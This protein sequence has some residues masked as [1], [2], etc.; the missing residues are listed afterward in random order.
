[1]NSDRVKTLEPAKVSLTPQDAQELQQFMERVRRDLPDVEVAPE[2]WV[3]YAA[4]RVEPGERLASVLNGPH[5]QEMYLCA[6]C[7][8]NRPG[9]LAFLE[10]RY[11]SGWSSLLGRMGLDGDTIADVVQRVRVKLVMNQPDKPGALSQYSGRGSLEAF[12][13][14]V[15]TRGGLDEL[16]QQ[17]RELRKEPLE[18]VDDCDVGHEPHLQLLKQRYRDEFTLAVKEGLDAL[19]EKERGL[20]RY[21]YLDG[22][23]LDD[24]ALVYAVHRATVARWLAKAR[25]NLLEATRRTLTTKLSMTE[26]DFNSI[27]RLI[28]SELHVSIRQHLQS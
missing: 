26:D 23:S 2:A 15:V 5:A 14:V 24:M 12:L 18:A 1:M 8:E 17:G 20:L 10:R 21:H 25:E 4:A 6:G 27:I 19:S 22:L 9:A 16:R 28:G 13:N 11:V 7:L 3:G